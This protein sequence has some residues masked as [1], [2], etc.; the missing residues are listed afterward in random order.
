M[1]DLHT[2]A[3]FYVVRR[4]SVIG[5]SPSFCMRRV[6]VTD[7]GVL[8]KIC[9]RIGKTRREKIRRRRAHYVAR[10]RERTG[11]RWKLSHDDETRNVR[12]ARRGVSREM[13]RAVRV[14]LT[15][16]ESQVAFTF[17]PG[18]GEGKRNVRETQGTRL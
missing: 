5:D 9:W 8:L 15:R 3:D 6:A 16:Q 18:G 7:A 10:R 11:L 13:E 1:F 12:Q 2:M 17:R 14:Y 4:A